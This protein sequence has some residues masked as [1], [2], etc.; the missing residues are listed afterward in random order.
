M[1]CFLL[2]FFILGVSHLTATEDLLILIPLWL[3][4][5]MRRVAWFSLL[6]LSWVGLGTG[7]NKFFFQTESGTILVFFIKIT[8]I[9][10]C[11][12]YL[13]KS[14]PQEQTNNSVC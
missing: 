7:F 4:R 14:T 11:I 3:V 6:A 13:V 12:I 2:G 9:A 1:F 10:S 5:D 8:V